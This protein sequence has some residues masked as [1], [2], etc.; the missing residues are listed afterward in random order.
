MGTIIAIDGPAASGKGTIARKVAGTLGYSYLDTGKLYRAVG[1]SMLT[2][3]LN[4]NAPEDLALLVY[5]ARRVDTRLLDNPELL[6]EEVGA[7]ASQVSVKPEIRT[8]LLGFQR[9]FAHEGKG[10]VLDGRDIGTVICPEAPYKFFVTA[11]AETRA[12]RRFKEL[13]TLGESVIYPDIL[14][15]LQERDERD[16]NRAIAPLVPA[17]DAI[18]IDTTSLD[19]EQAVAKVLSFIR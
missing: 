4:P 3:K 1:H 16:S 17:K 13:Q 14:K 7:A 12:Q 6:T 2:R 9:D 11:D 18:S 5:A 15:D 19:I 8:A 10:S